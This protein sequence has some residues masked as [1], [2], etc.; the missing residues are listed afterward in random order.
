MEQRGSLRAGV[1]IVVVVVE[2]VVKVA[3]TVVVVVEEE[4]KEEAVLIRAR[5]AFA[6]SEAAP[7]RPSPERQKESLGAHSLVLSFFFDVTVN[8]VIR[9]FKMLKNKKL[10]CSFTLK[11]RIFYILV[12]YV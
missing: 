7:L 10:N 11:F 1:G 5:I 4:K 12:P 9:T 6:S 2:V 3:P 8:N